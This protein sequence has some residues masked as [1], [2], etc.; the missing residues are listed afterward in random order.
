MPTLPQRPVTPPPPRTG[1]G[2]PP[3]PDPQT[4]VVTPPSVSTGTDKG[5]QEGGKKS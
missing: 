5:N 3:H 1:T 4:P 2:G